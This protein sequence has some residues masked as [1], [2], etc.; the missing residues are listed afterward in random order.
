MVRV[1][2]HGKMVSRKLHHTDSGRLYVMERKHGGGVKRK[3][4]RKR[5]KH[6]R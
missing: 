5:R 6:K 3:Y 1:R 2:C 4:L